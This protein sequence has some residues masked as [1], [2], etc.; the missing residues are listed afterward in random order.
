[1]QI[2]VVFLFGPLKKQIQL[3]EL[4]Q[5]GGVKVQRNHTNNTLTLSKTPVLHCAL[6]IF[7]IHEVTE[8]LNVAIKMLK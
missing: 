5:A 2:T 4:N 6:H 3:C 7:M 8:I 1:M